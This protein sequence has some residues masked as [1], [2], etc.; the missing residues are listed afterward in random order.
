MGLICL[1]YVGEYDLG[2][3]SIFLESQFLEF[4]RARPITNCHEATCELGEGIL[5][6]LLLEN[7]RRLFCSP[8][9]RPR[10]FA[11]RRFFYI[12]VYILLVILN[13]LCYRGS[14]FIKTCDYCYQYQFSFFMIA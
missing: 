12:S 5:M 8:G 9:L 4:H 11:Q 3:V 14:Q 2:L 10:Y 1:F 7:R 13:L 6:L